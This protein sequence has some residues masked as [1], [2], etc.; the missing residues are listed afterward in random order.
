M[1]PALPAPKSTNV[2]PQNPVGLLV[3]L[4]KNQLE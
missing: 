2:F 3:A 1:A 4:Q